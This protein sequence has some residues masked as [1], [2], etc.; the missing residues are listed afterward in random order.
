MTLI[1]SAIQRLL[2]LSVSMAA[3]L[4]MQGAGPRARDLGIPFTG[5]PGKL[6][7]ITDVAGVQV[8]HSTII[9]GKGPLRIG[10]GPIRT[11]VTAVLPTGKTQRP[12]FAAIGT[13][14]GNGELT[15]SHWV[16]ESGF[17]EEPILL[18]NTHSVGAVHEAVIKWRAARGYFPAGEEFEWA[19]LPV[20]AETWDG[21]LNDIHGFHVREK[22][23]FEALDAAVKGG[24]VTEGNVGGGTGMV[25]HRFKGGIGTASRVVSG[26]WTLGVLVQ[27]NYGLREELT[28]AGVPVGEEISD[29]QPLMNGIGP[30]GEGNSIIVV[31]ATDA[32]FLPHQLQRIVNRIP[33]GLAK[34]GGIGH[35]SSGDLF[36]GF[37]TAAITEGD[38]GIK[39]LQML[40][41]G[42]I[43][44]FFVATVQCVEEAILNA[45]VAAETMTG[46]NGNTV[47]ALPHEELRS[48]MKKYRRLQPSIAE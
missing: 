26:K 13:L 36:I 43:D 35:N 30:G 11:G 31:L 15:G 33:S 17:L 48:V 46:I 39:N 19:S 4:T 27:A 16:K 23:V 1:H 38:D 42:L 44:P 8:G 28:V 18:T 10:K 37:S 41:N 40:G 34:V 47:Y 29:K 9:S 22:H 24:L 3:C 2:L 21:R 32:P 6:N 7:A 14:N 5:T 25:C 12:V 20:V 45:M